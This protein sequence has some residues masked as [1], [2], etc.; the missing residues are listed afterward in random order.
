MVLS[1]TCL[2][3]KALWT[4]SITCMQHATF[5][6]LL[7]GDRNLLETVANVATSVPFIALGLQ[8]P[9]YSFSV[10]FMILTWQEYYCIGFNCYKYIHLIQ[11]EFQY[12]NVCKLTYRCWSCLKLVSLFPRKSKTVFEM[13]WLYNDSHSNSSKLEIHNKLLFDLW[14]H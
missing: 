1:M 7:L 13:G 8:A 14:N 10:H 5:S 4:R 12:K 9:R 3:A 6:W 11:E 2:W